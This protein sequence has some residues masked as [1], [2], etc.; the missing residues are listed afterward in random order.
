MG[1]NPPGSSVHGIFQAR[2]LEWVAIS[3]SRGSFPTQGSNLRLLPYRQIFYPLG[4][5][6]T[7]YSN[8]FIT[9]PVKLTQGYTHFPFPKDKEECDGTCSF[10][11]N[12]PCWRSGLSLLGIWWK[13]S[14]SWVVTCPKLEVT[15]NWWVL[16]HEYCWEAVALGFLSLLTLVNMS[17]FCGDPENWAKRDA[18]LWISSPC[19]WA[20]TWGAER[21]ALDYSR[22][23]LT[24]RSKLHLPEEPVLPVYSP[25]NESGAKHAP[26]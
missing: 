2:I 7:P 14:T 13:Y 5:Q 26:G 1:C 22:W 8:F 25:L 20:T 23:G 21:L 3:F 10:C 11:K 15:P 18:L 17:D 6:G 4:Y 12:R 24:C 19:F 16:Y 9:P